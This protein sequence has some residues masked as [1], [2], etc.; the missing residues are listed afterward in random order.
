MRTDLAE[1]SA[2]ILLLAIFLKLEKTR[3]MYVNQILLMRGDLGVFLFDSFR[4]CARNEFWDFVP[5]K[6]PAGSHQP[7]DQSG[8]KRLALLS[9]RFLILLLPF[10]GRCSD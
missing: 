9:R 8:I 7:V 10:A 5:G 6:R 3:D 4:S 2:D 1:K